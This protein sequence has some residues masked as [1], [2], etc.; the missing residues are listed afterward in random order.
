MLG[1]GDMCVY[2]E[3]TNPV[4][5][6]CGFS[7]SF[8]IKLPVLLSIGLA[9][10]RACKPF[11]VQISNKATNTKCVYFTVSSVNQNVNLYKVP[12]QKGSQR[13]FLQVTMFKNAMY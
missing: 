3:D 4:I 6:Y 11:I 8:D 12:L 1:T 9:L 5:S 13:W 7:D 10:I 2:L